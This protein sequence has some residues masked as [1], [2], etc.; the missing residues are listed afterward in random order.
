MTQRR[1]CTADELRVTDPFL[2]ESSRMELDYL[3]SLRPARLLAG[4][5]ATA[6]LPARAPRYGG[7]ESLD[8]QGH[9]MGHWL[10]AM[11]QAWQLTRRADVLA[12]MEEAVEGLSVCQRAD[13]YLFASPEALFDRLERGEEAWVPWYTMDKVLSGLLAAAELTP[14]A[15]AETVLRRLADWI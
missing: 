13:G 12:R 10:T 4:F 14:C 11:S 9:T 5:R 2:C 15:R 7:W 1:M 6:G 3:M 8:I